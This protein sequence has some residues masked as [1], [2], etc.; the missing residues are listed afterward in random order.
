MVYVSI[1][2]GYE[3]LGGCEDFYYIYNIR[4]MDTILT[5]EMRM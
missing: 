5:L 4:V 1:S 2:G 3:R